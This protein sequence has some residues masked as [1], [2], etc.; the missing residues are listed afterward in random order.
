M[1]L[2]FVTSLNWQELGYGD[3]ALFEKLVELQ[4]LVMAM[5]RKG[6]CPSRCHSHIFNAAACLLHQMTAQPYVFQVMLG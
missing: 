6:R 1:D 3:A 5:Q 4:L 2:H